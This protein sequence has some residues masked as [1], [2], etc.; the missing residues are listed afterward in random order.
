MHVFLQKDC[1]HG[2]FARG[3]GAAFPRD[4]GD[5]WGSTGVARG[6]GGRDGLY[7]GRA[8]N[9]EVAP[10]AWGKRS[11]VTGKTVGAVSGGHA[12]KWGQRRLE[13][14]KNCKMR[15]APAARGQ[16]SRVTEEMFGAAPG[17]RQRRL[18]RWKRLQTWRLHPLRGGNACA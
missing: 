11:R 9:M 14:W 4:G 15:V 5:V 2:G 18:V 8:A 3:A 6:S 10:A 17:V 7:V 16:R 12:G 1:E 13:R